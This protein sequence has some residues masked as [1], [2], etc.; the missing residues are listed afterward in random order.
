MSGKKKEL[1]PLERER[2]LTWEI[3]RDEE[4]RLLD[5]LTADERHIVTDAV[6]M[7]HCGRDVPPLEKGLVRFAL[8]SLI[9]RQLRGVAMR[10]EKAEAGAKGGSV[11][12]GAKAEAARANGQ[13]SKQS[14][15]DAKQSQPT[16]TVNDTVN[17]S[18]SVPV[19]VPAREAEKNGNGNQ[20]GGWNCGNE[21]AHKL[22]ATRVA[23]V[24][25]V[26]SG[27]DDAF[28]D[29][30]YDPAVICVAV[31]RDVKSWARW[32]QLAGKIPD[33]DM[34]Q[35]LLAF[36]RE[37]KSGEEPNNRGAAL[38]ARLGRM[39]GEVIQQRTASRANTNQPQGVICH[40]EGY[41]NPL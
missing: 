28:F 27:K 40:E 20:N 41:E 35:E 30:R 37:I 24:A 1:T 38:N 34:R 9:Q 13:I 15:A 21:E 32:R 10:N 36:Y 22:D 18:R 16:V 3:F 23:F 11:T 7:W 5:D 8:N 17:V 14:Q 4:E 25:E 19:T 2:G 12:G 33:A 6:M 29:P 26:K 31:S 39:A